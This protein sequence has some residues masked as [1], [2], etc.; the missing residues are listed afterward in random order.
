VNARNDANERFHGRTIPQIA[1]EL[2]KT[3]EDAA[4]DLVLEGDGRVMAI[5]H[6]M[7]ESDIEHGLR[8]PWTSIGSDAG[9]ALEAGEADV[10]GLPHP[11][12]YGTFP[13]IL[14]RH[15]RE[16]GVLTLEDAIRKMTS[17][18]A[19]RMRIPE[20]GIVK[21][22][23]FADVVVFDLETIEDRATWTEPT[24]FPTGIDYVLVNGE[25]VVDKG[26]HTGAKPGRALR[27]AGAR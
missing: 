23:F 11:R 19:T 25:I 20:R 22:G 4:W 12:S 27:G 1:T 5:Y 21:E 24:L 8:Y 15:V 18:P 26:R 16:R 2:S 3:P 7:S 17:W 6:M 13:R 9:A 10:L 14:A